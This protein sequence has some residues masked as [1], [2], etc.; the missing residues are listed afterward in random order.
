M[1]IDKKTYKIN[2]SNYYKSKFNKKQI[3]LAF[4]LRKD[5]HYLKHMQIKEFGKTKK[6]NTYTITRDGIVY[7][8][9]NPI[10]YTDF[11]GNKKIDKQSISIVIE[12]MGA[13]IKNDDKYINWVNEICDK[14][15]VIEFRWMGDKYWEIINSKQYNATIELCNKLCKDFNIN[16]NII[17]FH[18]YNKDANK[19]EG[20]LFRSNI[21]E[22]TTDINPTFDIDKINNWLKIV[23]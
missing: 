20:I 6:W 1:N 22:D 12:N 10:Y 11:I 7:E 23:I 19:F 21:I 4:S 14:K 9:Y 8:H 17:D 2:P 13:L 3:I 15:N 5:D 18:S 16:K